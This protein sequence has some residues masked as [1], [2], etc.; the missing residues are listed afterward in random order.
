VA[1]PTGVHVSR[2]SS[3]SVNV[4]WETPASFGSG[5]ASYNLAWRPVGSGDFNGGYDIHDVSTTVCTVIDLIPGVTYE[6]RMTATDTGDFKASAA[7]VE[8]RLVGDPPAGVFPPVTIGGGGTATATVEGVSA[9][10][11]L[12]VDANVA[13][14]TTGVASV[15]IDGLTITVVPKPGFSGVIELP[16][17]VTQDGAS[18][19]VI[20]HITVN[21]GDP[22]NVTFGPSSSTKTRV[23]WAG[24]LNATGYRVYVGG[25]AVATVGPT[26]SSYDYAKLLGPNAVVAVQAIGG[27]G[28]FSH[29]VRATYRPGAPITIGTITFAGDSAKLTTSAKKALQKLAALVKAQGFTSLTIKGFTEKHAHGS[30]AFRK[31]LSAARAKAV[32][33]F[34]TAEFKR[35]HVKV[36]FI[37]VSTS[38]STATGSTKYRRAE[39]VLTGATV[40]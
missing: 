23:Q 3:I 9:D 25:S 15:T 34:L 27:G 10:A 6:F 1:A 33:A 36:S 20:A 7:P 30:I 17:T 37:V 35:L 14:D 22:Y 38:G 28:T 13:Q 40:R 26:I 31:R 39:I 18:S 29:V 32:T 16:V 21:P 12:T 5:F 8:F 2:V 24:S 4:S 11:S 19:T